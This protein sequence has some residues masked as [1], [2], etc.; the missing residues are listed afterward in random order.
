MGHPLPHARN[1]RLAWRPASPD[2]ANFDSPFGLANQ[3][4]GRGTNEKAGRKKLRYQHATARL[5]AAR[6][7]IPR[8]LRVPLLLGWS[9]SVGRIVLSGGPGHSYD[10]LQGSDGGQDMERDDGFAS[11]QYRGHYRLSHSGG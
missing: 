10:C 4:T 9:L 5:P 1:W 7:R 2:L 3:A 6:G 8:V 11:A